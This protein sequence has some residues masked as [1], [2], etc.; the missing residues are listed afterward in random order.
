VHH[1][2]ARPPSSPDLEAGS[3]EGGT[4]LLGA[5]RGGQ[6]EVVKVLVKAGVYLCLRPRH[7]MH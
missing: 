4:A 3:G 7:T 2:M 6:V 1:A 5:V